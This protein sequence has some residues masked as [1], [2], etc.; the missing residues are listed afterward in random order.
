M[1]PMQTL[2]MTEHPA[3][4][5]CGMTVNPEVARAAGLVTEHDGHTYFFCGR[6]CQF[7]FRDDPARYLDPAWEKHM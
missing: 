7:D 1:T 2:H 4:P 3:D 6:G 5:V